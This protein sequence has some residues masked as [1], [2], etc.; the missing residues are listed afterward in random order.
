[1]ALTVYPRVYGESSLGRAPPGTGR[2]LSP[3]VRGIPAS[4]RSAHEPV[5]SIPA[6]TGNPSTSK[7]LSRVPTVY[8]RVYGESVIAPHANGVE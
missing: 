3:R 8:P 2:G 4:V 7:L 1:M 6:C 5:R